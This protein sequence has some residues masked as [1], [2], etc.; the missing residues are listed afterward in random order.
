MAVDRAVFASIYSKLTSAPLL[1]YPNFEEAF[2]VD[3]DASDDGLG[4]V[5]SQN[6]Q[7]AEHVVYYASRTLTKAK[8]KYCATR[9]EMLALVW[10][11]DQF[12]PYLYGRPFIVRTD[13]HALQ[14]LRSFKEPEGQV[15]RWLEQVYSSAKAW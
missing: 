4:T 2:I 3:C 9:K 6:H 13:H 14:W 1:V 15:A 11:I 5:L 8:R 10:A 12:R 7:G